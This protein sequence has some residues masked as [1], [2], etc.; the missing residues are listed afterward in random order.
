MQSNAQIIFDCQTTNQ[1]R[2]HSH[3]NSTSPGHFLPP[4]TERG[5]QGTH[6]SVGLENQLG[7]ILLGSQNPDI[8]S[9]FGLSAWTPDAAK[10]EKG[11][12]LRLA[13]P[14]GSE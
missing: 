5:P 14:L 9:L 12:F 6:L 1:R 11:S 7:D 10:R 2:R 3:W 13:E 8:L 4:H